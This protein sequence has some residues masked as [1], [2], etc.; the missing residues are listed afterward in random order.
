MPKTSTTRSSDISGISPSRA[1]HRSSLLDVEILLPEQVETSR[2]IRDSAEISLLWAIFCDGIQ[3]YCREVLR[4]STDSLAYREVHRWIFRSH[5]DAVTSFASL[6]DLFAI[7]TRKLRL[8]LTRFREHPSEA[9]L[10]TL[11]RT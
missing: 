8:A 2:G 4:S 3:T 6:C 1:G 9:L 10:G 7:D 11:D 5:S